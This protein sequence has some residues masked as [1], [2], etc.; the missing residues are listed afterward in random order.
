M[1]HSRNFGPKWI[2]WITLWLHSSQSC[3]NINGELTD[4]FYCKRGI[5]QGDP[6][7]PFLYILAVDILSKLFYKGRQAIVLQ[8]LGPPCVDDRPI[9]NYHY[10]DDTILFLSAQDKNVENAWWVIMAFETLSGIK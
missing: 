9:T 5:R 1:L 7:S 6:L 8:G 4:Y 2:Q 3:I 10:A